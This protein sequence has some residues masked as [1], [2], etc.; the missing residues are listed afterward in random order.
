LSS[1]KFLILISIAA[2]SV[3]IDQMSKIY[4]HTQMLLGESI[5][6]VTDFFSITYVRNLGAAFGFLSQSDPT[7]RG[8]F[9]LAL[10]PLA[11]IAILLLLMSHKDD[12][13]LEIM[14]LAAIFGGALGNYIDRVRFGYVI[15]FLDF[16]YKNDYHYPAF[17]VADISI[18]LGVSALF[19]S[20]L[21]EYIE[22]RKGLKKTKASSN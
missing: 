16:H 18:I 12:E 11:M 21:F 5:P 2:V 13:K 9:F 10:P 15:D 14:A 7:F 1:A 17:N 6:V 4:V 22:E 19:L 8:I 3:C 20:I